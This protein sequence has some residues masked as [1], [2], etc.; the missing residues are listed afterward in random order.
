M[1]KRKKRRSIH[2][3]VP[4]VEAFFEKQPVFGINWGKF[5]L[6]PP[7]QRLPKEP[8]GG[9]Q[10]QQPPKQKPKPKPS[11]PR[12]K[13]LPVTPPVTPPK[14]EKG[15]STQRTGY[16]H[17]FIK[18]GK[19]GKPSDVQIE[20]VSYEEALS[21]CKKVAHGEGCS[22]VSTYR[23]VT[24]TYWG[25]D[26]RDRNCKKVVFYGGTKVLCKDYFLAKTYERRLQSL[27]K[28]Y[29]RELK[30]PTPMLGYNFALNLIAKYFIDKI[31]EARK[32]HNPDDPRLFEIIKRLGENGILALEKA[33]E[34]MQDMTPNIVNE[35]QYEELKRRGIVTE[36]CPIVGTSLKSVRENGRARTL[37]CREWLCM[38]PEGYGLELFVAKDDRWCSKNPR[39]I[40][41]LKA[42]Y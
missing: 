20:P 21:H 26:T 36:T 25:P 9:G 4:R 38:R 34:L 19:N 42:P 7:R 27:A 23:G 5:L 16:V 37:Y 40:E 32:Q 39:D 30:G 31:E 6:K 35:R 22:S 11:P 33:K 12:I 13:P 14:Q 3:P 18:F 15:K 2:L 28:E 24:E 41:D 29:A 17:I 8:I 10:K 1:Q